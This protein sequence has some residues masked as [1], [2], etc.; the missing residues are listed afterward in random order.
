[1]N[2]S[3]VTNCYGCMACIDICP[4]QCIQHKKDSLGHIYPSVAQSDCIDCGACTKNCPSINKITLHTPNTVWAAWKKDK[5]EK[6]ESSSG[7][8]AA[9]LSEQIIKEGGIVYGC[10]FIPP[11][12]FKHIRCESLYELNSLKGSKYVQSNMTGI[13]KQIKSDLE[14]KKKVLFIGTPCQTA[15][16]NLF[17]KSKNSNLFTIDLVCHGAPSSQILKDSIPKSVQIKAFNKIKFREQAN[18]HFSIINNDSV[19]YERKLNKDL[20]LKGFFTS[21]FNRDSCYKCQYAQ[22]QRNSDITL[23]DFWGVNNKVIPFNVKEGVSLCMINTEKGN[24]LFNAVAVKIEKVQRPVNEAIKNN[25][26]L[27]KP[28]PFKLRSK[29]FKTL[30]PIIGFKLGVRLSIPEIILKNIFIRK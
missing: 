28:A 4:K 8:I 6:A 30:Y 13:Y 10:A 18:Y 15:A 3:T 21:L 29:I 23:G 26:P 24:N 5:V 17:F 19:L 1:M 9:A 11:F 20:Y 27:N 12:S 16:V 14:D 22:K 7:G 25:E 2:I